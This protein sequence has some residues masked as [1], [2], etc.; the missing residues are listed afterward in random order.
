MSDDAP[1]VQ[2]GALED[3]YR[4]PADPDEWERVYSVVTGKPCPTCGTA[5][6]VLL[7][8]R[9]A[10]DETAKQI[11]SDYGG[12]LSDGWHD[13]YDD[14]AYMYCDR[15]ACPWHGVAEWTD[16][17]PSFESWIHGDAPTW[18]QRVKAEGDE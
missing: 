3:G 6:G 5:I 9:D 8:P 17:L 12:E 7:G 2:L 10:L 14:P 11:N 16:L 13:G 1:D 18:Q 15:P 4:P